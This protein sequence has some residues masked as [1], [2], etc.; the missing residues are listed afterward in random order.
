MRLPRGMGYHRDEQDAVTENLR[1]KEENTR[2]QA[3]VW[4]L[5]DNPTLQAD[6]TVAAIFRLSDAQFQKKF[7]VVRQV[8]SG[9]YHSKECGRSSRNNNKT[10]VR[11]MRTHLDIGALTNTIHL[12]KKPLGPRR[13]SRAKSMSS[14]RPCSPE[15][16]LD[17]TDRMTPTS[18]RRS[19][20][21]GPLQNFSA[22]RSPNT[23]EELQHY[24]HEKIRYRFERVCA[25][26]PTP[27]SQD[28][29]SDTIIA[30]SSGPEF[31][32]DLSTDEDGP[33]GAQI[34]STPRSRTDFPISGRGTPATDQGVGVF[35][36]SI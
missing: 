25:N 8:T 34:A 2:L 23:A 28:S 13:L 35:S 16:N 17:T 1:L 32:I 27:S 24:Y 20:S 5:R 19:E 31:D 22:N 30:G 7:S 9:L 12:I 21:A 18:K 11:A 29:D 15:E 4:V 14:N 26:V 10:K 3:A 33:S 6:S 36:G